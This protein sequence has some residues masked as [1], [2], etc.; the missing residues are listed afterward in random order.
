MN[1]FRYVD[2]PHVN[3]PIGD[4]VL[5]AHFITS[6]DGFSDSNVSLVTHAFVTYQGRN[7]RAPGFQFPADFLGA[8]GLNFITSNFQFV[9]P[10]PS[11]GVAGGVGVLILVISRRRAAV[12]RVVAL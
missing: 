11:V 2:V 6:G 5:G 12:R 4:Y 7:S 1:S 3:L 10:E 9:V 8:N